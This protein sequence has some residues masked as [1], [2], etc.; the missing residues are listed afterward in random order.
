MRG[1]RPVLDT[2]HR[3]RKNITHTRTHL[4]PA[5]VG[6]PYMGSG[7]PEMI[8]PVKTETSSHGEK[9]LEFVSTNLHERI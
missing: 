3:H 4:I 9:G 6:P 7:L 5:H 8:Q 1:R 2:I